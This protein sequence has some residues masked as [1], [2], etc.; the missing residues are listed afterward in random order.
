[1]LVLLY[2]ILM[3]LSLFHIV[4]RQIVAE[5]NDNVS[6]YFHVQSSIKHREQAWKNI[7]CHNE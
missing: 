7:K 6:L 1:M 3:T 2:N 5:Q 4:V